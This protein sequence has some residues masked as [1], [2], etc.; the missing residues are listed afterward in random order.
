MTAESIP[1]V[2]SLPVIGRAVRRWRVHQ[3]A[4][5]VYRDVY[6]SGG[7]AALAV[8]EDGGRFQRVVS[9]ARRLDVPATT[10][11]YELVVDGRV[12]DMET[13]FAAAVN[14]VRDAFTV[15]QAT[16]IHCYQGRER[17]PTVTATALAAELDEPFSAMVDAIRSRRPCVEPTPALRQAADRYLNDTEDVS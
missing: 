13:E 15:G 14:T 3:Y 10:D 17:A 4:D 7:R 5:E 11:S 1:E 6:V 9:V 8:P 16:L 12:L 2:Q